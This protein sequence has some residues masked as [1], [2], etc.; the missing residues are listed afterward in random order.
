MSKLFIVEGVDGSGKTTLAKKLTQLTRGV[1]LHASGRT[2]IHQCMQAYHHELLKTAE[3]NLDLGAPAVILDRHWP[4][5]LCYGAILRPHHP[6][7]YD[8]K[9]MVNLCHALG[10]VYIYCNGTAG[11]DEHH[12]THAQS[13]HHYQ[14]TELVKVNIEYAILFEDL[15]KSALVRDYDRSRVALH[16]VELW[17]K[18]ILL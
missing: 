14:Q 8:A 5:E 17:I 6:Y 18:E 10:A 12:K 7:P 9:G 15:S 4:S 16:D 13:D 1:Y 11:I 3:Q 2:D